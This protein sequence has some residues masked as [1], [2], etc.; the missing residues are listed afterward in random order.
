MTE[1]VLM[2]LNRSDSF[3]LETVFEVTFGVVQL[4]L[5]PR[6]QGLIWPKCDVNRSVVGSISEE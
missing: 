5:F 4:L 3:M 2:L 1:D 6:V